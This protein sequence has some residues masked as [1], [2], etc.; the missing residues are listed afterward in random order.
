MQD[1]LQVF[2]VNLRDRYLSVKVI[3]TVVSSA[4]NIMCLQKLVKS[5]VQQV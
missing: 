3:H 2:V 5:T 1:H 4:C